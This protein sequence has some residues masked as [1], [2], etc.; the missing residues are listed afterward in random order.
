M[1]QGDTSAFNLDD[2]AVENKE[3]Y[4]PFKD[5]KLNWEDLRDDS[6]LILFGIGKGYAKKIF[7]FKEQKGKQVSWNDI[8]KISGIGP[9]TIEKLKTFLILE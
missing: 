8:S 7:D 2:L 9:K 1:P 6:Q 3:I 4:V 5:Y